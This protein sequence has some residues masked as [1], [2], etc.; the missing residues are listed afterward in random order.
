VTSGIKTYYTWGA[1]ESGSSQTK[2]FLCIETALVPTLGIAKVFFLYHS[3]AKTGKVNALHQH[4]SICSTTVIPDRQSSVRIHINIIVFSSKLVQV[5]LNCISREMCMSVCLSVRI[6]DQ[7]QAH[8]QACLPI[9][10][11]CGTA[12]L[13]CHLYSRSGRDRFQRGP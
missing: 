2:Y 9:A 10:S 5:L 11:S 4:P 1:P 12:S 8:P 13:R 6:H 3:F 7:A